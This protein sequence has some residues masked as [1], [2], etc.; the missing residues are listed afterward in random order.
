MINEKE[1][2]LSS[3]SFTNKDFASIY[4]EIL[5]LTQKISPKWNPAASN[6]SDPGVVLL[7]L[8]AFVGDKLNYNIDKNTLENFMP[9]ATQESSMWKLC[10]MNGYNMKYYV[11]ATTNVYFTYT[12]EFEG[13]IVIPKYSIISTEDETLKFVTL[14]DATISERGEATQTPTLVIEGTLKD[15]TI[16]DSTTILLEN[17]D[18]SNRIYFSDVAVAENGVFVTNQ[19]DSSIEWTR[20][21]NLNSQLPGSTIFVFGYDSTS[22]LPYIQFPEDVANLMGEGLNIKYVVSSGVDGNVNAKALT[23]LVSQLSDE[24]LD[25]SN[26]VI[27]NPNATI[28]GANPET[29]DEAYNNSKKI[30]GVFDTLVSTRDYANAIYFLQDSD[31]SEHNLVSN[32]QVADRRTDLNYG[33]NVKTLDENG[34]HITNLPSTIDAFTL[35]IYSLKPIYDYSYSSYNDS[36]SPLLNLVNIKLGLEDKK[37][38]SHDYKEFS[39]VADEDIIYLIKNNYKLNAKIVTTTKVNSFE[40]L[41]ILQNV[42]NALYINFNSRKVD[43]GYEIPYDTLVNVITEADSRIKLVVL[44]E[45]EL[46]T[47]V[48][49][50]SGNNVVYLPDANKTADELI[51]NPYLKV[52]AKN[53]IKGTIPLFSYNTDFDYDFGVKKIAN[54]PSYINNLTKAET[55]VIVSGQDLLKGYTP[56]KNEYIQLV[57]P[58][59]NTELT[60]SAYVNYR[61]ESTNVDEITANSEYQ[62]KSGDVLYLEYQ[63]S[64]TDTY[65]RYVYT[66]ADGSIKKND[67]VIATNELLVFKPNF[68]LKKWGSGVYGEY[69]PA[70]WKDKEGDNKR[71]ALSANESIEKRNFVKTNI[72]TPTLP[73][74]WIRPNRENNGLFNLSDAVLGADGITPVEFRTILGQDDYFIYTDSSFSSLHILGSGTQLSIK[75][76]QYRNAKKW[77][78]DTKVSINTINEKGLDVIPQSSW[79]YL[80][81][82]GNNNALSI[83]QMQVLILG[84]GDIVVIDDASISTVSSKEWKTLTNGSTI[85]YSLSDGTT[86]KLISNSVTPWQIRTRLDIVASPSTSQKLLENQTITLYYLDGSAEKSVELLYDSTENRT[87]KINQ[88]L[89]IVGPVSSLPYRYENALDA[90]STKIYICSATIA[91]EVGISATGDSTANLSRNY[92]GFIRIDATNFEKY[93]TIV[94]P[95]MSPKTENSSD[96]LTEVFVIYWYLGNEDATYSTPAKLSANKVG[97]TNFNTSDTITY[98]QEITLEKGLNTIQINASDEDISQL[99]LT[100]PVLASGKTNIGD[101]V[102]IG[103]LKIANGLNEGLSLTS[104]SEET[105]LLRLVRTLSTPTSETKSSFYYTN[106]IENSMIIDVDD[107]SSPEALWSANNVAN[108]FTLA[109]ID[110]DNSSITIAKSSRL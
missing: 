21:Y 12:G 31:V 83:Q 76:Q 29:I 72:T 30:V 17:L 98:Q 26:L 84:E 101:F 61:F 78:L 102:L 10:A 1:L 4:T 37:T 52:M 51:N 45:P 66:G 13:S 46:V 99:V 15:L 53:I 2:Q 9:S 106:T 35:C 109:A 36:Y 32:V 64:S 40:Q 7:K 34:E 103:Q 85:T 49:S 8:A 14:S 57:S 70:Y 90:S 38:L 44:E 55:N 5:D 23:N 108:R 67:I 74:Y 68:N 58:N 91:N 94:L 81:C 110:F 87:I 22:K 24:S 96:S 62:L 19:G 88:D 80:D 59:L 41:D 93:K 28:N 79:V 39:S 18:D 16:N 86:T 75:P 95:T 54:V 50:P 42:Y 89:T 47:S 60:F 6:E 48:V 65:E 105:A 71:L 100:L 69:T 97:I 25:K 77:E 33:V 63:S 20:V 11:S 73:C 107:L 56:R 3:K 43:Y 92:N 82:S 104:A 27:T